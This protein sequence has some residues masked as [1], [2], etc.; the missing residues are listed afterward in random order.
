MVAG[1]PSFA[2][3]ADTLH[4]LLADAVF[5]AHNARFD[6][7]FVRNAFRRCGVAFEAE[8]LCTVKLSRALHPEHA[9][10]GLDALIARA[11]EPAPVDEYRVRV[12]IYNDDGSLRV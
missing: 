10:H 8:V 6:Y 1:A 3:L 7:G 12:A 4:E 9:R 11:K 5:V 2:S